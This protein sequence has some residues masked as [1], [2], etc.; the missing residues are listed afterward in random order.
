MGDDT[1]NRRCERKKEKVDMHWEPPHY[2]AIDQGCP[3]RSIIT[4]SGFSLNWLLRGVR[5]RLINQ[6]INGAGEFASWFP[7]PSYRRGTRVLLPQEKAQRP[8]DRVGDHS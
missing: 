8:S 4:F 3:H 5:D 2:K 7:V 6:I 1:E